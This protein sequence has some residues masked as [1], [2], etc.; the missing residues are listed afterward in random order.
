MSQRQPRSD[1]ID[2]ARPTEPEDET[3]VG[4]PPLFRYDLLLAAIPLVLLL[5]WV[6]GQFSDA[7]HWATLAAGA[8]VVLP[9]LAD[10][11]AVNPPQ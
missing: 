2:I 7:P 4:G 9:L 8:L 10:G 5:G 11:L 1:S 3:F 6:V